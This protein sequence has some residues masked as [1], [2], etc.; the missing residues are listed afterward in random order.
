MLCGITLAVW[1]IWT[2][3]CSPKQINIFDVSN[4]MKN[5]NYGKNNFLE[6]GQKVVEEKNELNEC[7]LN[8]SGKKLSPL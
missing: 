6:A 1:V 3:E 7:R 2:T 4:E 8:D 5:L